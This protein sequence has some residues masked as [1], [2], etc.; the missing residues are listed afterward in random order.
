M[1][2]WIVVALVVG[3]LGLLGYGAFT[4][5]HG[6]GVL[7]NSHVMCGEHVMK[8]GDT[9]TYTTDDS[10]TPQKDGYESRRDDQTVEGVIFTVVGVLSIAGALA[11]MLGLAF[12][13]R[14]LTARI[15]KIGG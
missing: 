12:A 2:A 7:R 1:K 4:L 9:C 14:R 3:V 8:P 10:D 13:P 6:L 5:D 11:L 15:G